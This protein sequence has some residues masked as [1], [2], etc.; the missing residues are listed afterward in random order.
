[1]NN[2]HVLKEDHYDH[3]K[4][5][6]AVETKSLLPSGTQVSSIG[7]AYREVREESLQSPFPFKARTEIISAG[8]QP[9]R[10]VFVVNLEEI[11]PSKFRESYVYNVKTIRSDKA[12]ITLKEPIL[13]KI[14]QSDDTISC[15][16]EL[17]G[18]S[19]QGESVEDAIS[20]FADFFIFDYS[21]YKE[22]REKELTKGAKKLLKLYKSIIEKEKWQ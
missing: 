5:Y 11:K 14:E 12:T 13:L 8:Y 4:N 19:S 20:N 7:T 9:V 21:T 17:L 16:N 10:R 1:M 22:S 2:L 6:F 3:K 18:L 15:F